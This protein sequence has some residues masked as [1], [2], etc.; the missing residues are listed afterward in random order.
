M[1]VDKQSNLRKLDFFFQQC[2]TMFTISYYG[3]MSLIFLK[4]LCY[5]NNVCSLAHKTS[6][7]RERFSLKLWVDSLDSLSVIPWKS[8]IFPNTLCYYHKMGI[9]YCVHDFASL[10]HSDLSSLIL[11]VVVMRFLGGSVG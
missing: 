2:Q 5:F 1:P 9:Y 7:S 8:Y 6:L 11:K 4:C 3:S 10:F